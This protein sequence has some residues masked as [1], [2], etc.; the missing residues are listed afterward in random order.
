MR[1]AGLISGLTML[2]RILGLVRE[3]V[4]AAL[5]GAGAYADAFQV[6]FRIPNL[7]RDLFSEGAL[8]AAFVPTY[9]RALKEGGPERAHQLSAR[10]MSV[11]FVVLALIVLLGLVFTRPLVSFLAPGFDPAKTATTVLLTRIMLPFLPL[12]SFAALAMGMLNAEGRFGVPAAAPAMFNV[13]SITWALVLWALGFGPAEVAIGWA[14]GTVLGGAAQFGVQVP[15]LWKRGFRFRPEW[16]PGDPGIRSV[17]TLMLPATIGLAAVEVNI[18][19]STKFASHEDGAVAW[20]GYA[21]RILYLPIGIFGVAV[22][23]VATSG[24]ARSAAAG[25]VSGLRETLR[26]ALGTVAFLS[27]PATAGLIVLAVPIVRL[28]FER[29]AFTPSDTVHTG[30]ALALYAVGLV[31]YASVKV[32]APAF[33]ALARPRIPLLASFSAVVTNLAFIWALHGHM[34]YRAIALGTALGSI[35]NVLVLFIAFERR[36]GGLATRDLFW[37]LARMIVAAAAMAAVCYGT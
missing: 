12:V 10:L 37:S 5:L 2:S 17:A 29:G 13:V 7:L 25:D 32:L 16:Q 21:F 19:V 27:I 35:V 9:A 30:D 31:A 20:L 24:L 28:L 33:Y 36:V 8:S 26:R 4:F 18:I 3:Q 6:A 23:T 34:G 22:G 14:I 1:S 15:S 11:L